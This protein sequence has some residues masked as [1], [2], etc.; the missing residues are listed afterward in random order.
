VDYGARG[1]LETLA[2]AKA[3]VARWAQAGHENDE[4]CIRPLVDAAA[5]GDESARRIVD[6]TATL[7]GMAA[8]NLSVI[9]DPSL[10]VL[11]GT[12]FSQAPEI[13]DDVRRIVARIVPTPSP[14]VV[15]ALDK[16]AALWGALLVAT[17]EGRTRLRERVRSLKSEV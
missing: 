11:G 15:S 9:L 3:V 1:C 16:E 5:A 17:R 7:I 13:A 8:A 2:G 4:G 6:D 12:L 10:I 14:I